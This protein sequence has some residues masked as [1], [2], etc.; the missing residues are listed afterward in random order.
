MLKTLGSSLAPKTKK[1][2]ASD[3]PPRQLM[4]STCVPQ[5]VRTVA[6]EGLRAD[7]RRHLQCS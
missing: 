5:R 7:N 4:Y 1:G 6:G 2:G 3:R